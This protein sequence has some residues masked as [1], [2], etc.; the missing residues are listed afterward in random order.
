MKRW[1]P[2]AHIAVTLAVTLASAALAAVQ[3]ERVPEAEA[4]TWFVFRIS[5]S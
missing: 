3:T 4:A 5:L 1:Y 2:A